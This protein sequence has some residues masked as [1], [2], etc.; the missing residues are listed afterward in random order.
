MDFKVLYFVCL[1]IVFKIFKLLVVDRFL[2]ASLPIA[3]MSLPSLTKIKMWLYPPEDYST[4]TV[5]NG[6]QHPLGNGY[7][8]S[9]KI[10]Q[11]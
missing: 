1:L 5:H 8:T 2:L 4:T 11:H 3:T 6:H 7:S 10:Q 9:I